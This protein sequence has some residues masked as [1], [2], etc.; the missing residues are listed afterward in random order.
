[1]QLIKSRCSVAE[2]VVIQLITTFSVRLFAEKKDALNVALK[3][4]EMR[5]NMSNPGNEKS[6]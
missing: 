1:M 4:C 5:H 2:H 3:L 6:L